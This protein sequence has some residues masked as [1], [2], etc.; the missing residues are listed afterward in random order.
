VAG[1]M[2]D[3]HEI[4]SDGA[5]VAVTRLSGAVLM[6]GGW[7]RVGEGERCDEGK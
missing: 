5:G 1:V 7:Q 3:S 6:R 2:D 4:R